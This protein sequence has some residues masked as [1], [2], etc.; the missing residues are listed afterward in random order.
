MPRT[1]VKV[2]QE[3]VRLGLEQFRKDRH[4]TWGLAIRQAYAKR[5]YLVDTLERSRDYLNSQRIH[6]R[7][8]GLEDAAEYV[9]IEHRGN[10]T[11]TQYY[12]Y[13]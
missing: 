1:L 12:E 11:V 10:R 3:W 9:D 4:T 8:W 7:T 2:V 6:N 13:L 5:M